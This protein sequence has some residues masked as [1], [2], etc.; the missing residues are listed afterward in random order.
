VVNTIGLGPHRI[1]HNPR[2]EWFWDTGRGGHILVDIASHQFEQFLHFTG[3]TSAR[4]L[5]S[6]EANFDNPERTGWCDYGHA[7]V[8]SDHAT[9][10]VRVDW[11]TAAGSP[12]W[13]DGRLFVMGTE[14][15]IELRKY[16]DT[17]GRPGGD[18]LFLTDGKGTRYLDCSE[19]ELDYGPRLRDDVL[20][21][22]ETAMRQGQCFLAMELALE[23]H[24]LAV[25]LGGVRP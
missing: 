17:E 10:F 25:P 20:N 22:T 3:S 12:A 2:P 1:G 6:V 16:M 14:G 7:V 9:G 19:V 13:G 4:V 21:R 18:H 23:A 8:A 24:R 5:Q 11:M 15:N